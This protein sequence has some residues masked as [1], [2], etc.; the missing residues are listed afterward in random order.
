MEKRLLLFFAVAFLI[1]TQWPRL[2]P[3]PEAAPA[4]AGDIE[5]GRKPGAAEDETKATAA[6]SPD[7][8]AES[9]ESPAPNEAVGSKIGEGESAATAPAQRADA[10]ETVAV[11]TDRYHLEI[12]NRGGA[13]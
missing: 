7:E 13:S 2:F 3:P 8:Q 11:E 6:A 9:P 12:S 10:E 4:A 1:I 5:A